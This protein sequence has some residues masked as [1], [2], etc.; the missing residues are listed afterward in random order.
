MCDNI[1]IDLLLTGFSMASFE[2]D[3]NGYIKVP[4]RIAR[5]GELEYTGAEIG[6]PG[7]NEIY[8][9]YRTADELFSKETIDSFEGMPIT[10]A[11]PED[12]QVNAEDWSTKA[13]GHIQGVKPDGEYLTC[14]AYIQDANAIKVIEDDD[15][16]ELSCGYDAELRKDGDK[17]VQYG[18]IGNHVA[19]VPEGRC[20]STCRL[21]DKKGIVMTQKTKFGDSA[22][23]VLEDLKKLKT[24]FGDEDPADKADE[25]TT[26]VVEQLDELQA[27]V[28]EIVAA[29]DEADQAAAEAAKNKDDQPM[30]DADPELEAKVEELEARVAQLE[31]E[32]EEL[33]AELEKYRTEETMN[34]AKA[35]FPDVKF[36]D[37]KSPRQVK[38]KILV[39]KG[40]FADSA[41]KKQSDDVIDA[42]YA[43]IRAATPVKEDIGSKFIRAN[44][45]KAAGKSAQ[46]RLGGK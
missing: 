43:G 28:E 42:A 25:K 9:V 35:R 46:S 12:L 1:P 26:E 6:E 37:C 16:I 32:N 10:I 13:V 24:K 40:A 7:N 4:A 30:A 11:H 20:G 14:T 34:D 5:T 2:K 29:A 31:A 8:Y 3:Q 38:E 27:A 17:L 41:I 23:K 33:K 19:I 22:K 21:G 36:G 18:I 39:T 45:K 15:V 44:D